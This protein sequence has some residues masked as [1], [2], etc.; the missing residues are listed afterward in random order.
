MDLLGRRNCCCRVGPTGPT[1]PSGATGA[2]GPSGAAGATG[3]SGATGATGPSGAAGATGPT[4][5]SV[6]LASDQS[7]SNNGWLGLGTSSSQSQFSRSTVVI[8]RNSTIREVI[9]NT[10]NN[11]LTSAETVTATVFVSPCGASNPVNTGISATVA[12][13]NSQSNC[14]AV[15]TGNYS[16]AQNSLMSVRIT[17]GPNNFALSGGAAVTVILTVP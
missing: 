10:R 5:L 12:G 4:L 16:V 8:P 17:T 9:L 13:A 3:P 6:Y 7:I 14:S 15:G 11:S 2:T 1:G